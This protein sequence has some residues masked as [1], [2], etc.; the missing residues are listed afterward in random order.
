MHRTNSLLVSILALS[1][2]VGCSKGANDAPVKS[3]N[4]PAAPAPSA[5]T[6]AKTDAPAATTT[7]PA[8]TPSAPATTTAAAKPAVDEKSVA[9]LF[10]APLKVDGKVI[11]IDEMKRYLACG[12]GSK[13]AE[14]DKFQHIIAEELERRK[15]AG[16]D[17]S[18]LTP[19]QADVDAK[20]EKDRKDFALKYPTLDFATEVGRAFL[21]LDLYREQAEQAIQFDRVFTPVNPD[22]W[23][24]ETV[25]II[26]QEGGPDLVQDAHDSYAARKKKMED[27][28]LAEIPPDDPIYTEY[29]R[30]V[31]VEALNKFATSETYEGRLPAGV[32]MTVDGRPVYVD[33]VFKRI[34][35]HVT[36]NLVAD[37]KKFLALKALLEA[38]LAK[39]GLLLTREEFEKQWDADGPVKDESFSD[40]LARFQMLGLQ[41]QGYPSMD[42]YLDHERWILSFKKSIADELK[43]DAKLNTVIGPCDAI[44]GA[45]KVDVEVILA[46]A[47][48]DVH[49]RWKDGGWAYAEQRAKDIKKELDSGAD[50]GATLELKS[51]FWDPPM[52]EIGQKPQFGFNYKGRFG[53]QTRNQLIEFLRESEY[54]VF[55]D[56]TCITDTIF[57]KQKPGTI[58][59]PYKGARGYYIV[60]V[61]GTT[62]PN[63]PLDL[64]TPLHRDLVVQYYLKEKFNAYAQELLNKAIAEKRV[65]G[66]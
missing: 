11:S 58:E 1:V 20:I 22:D 44:C 59:G 46:S 14:H 17:I 13:Q 29:L 51:E 18:G 43:D 53:M 50:W 3:A 47:Y 4:T 24:P 33:Q 8:A 7:P 6:A 39:K 45:A 30:G 56:G 66:L 2:A 63:K 16:Q 65:E 9:A 25:E 61:K 12:L 41:V 35:P 37:A 62:P 60:K 21:S 57:F 36:P 27:E 5:P 15:A 49:D 54:R 26:R 64:N 10:G 28:H 52:P 23:S 32:L 55:L 19:T 31:I 38:D 48:D 34:V 40:K 42:A